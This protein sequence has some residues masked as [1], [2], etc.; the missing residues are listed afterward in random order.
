MDDIIHL[1]PDAVAN[2][3]AAGEVIQRP[4]SAV[5]EL[6]ENA[7]DAGATQIQ[8]VIK[9]AGRTLI[10]VCDNGKGMSFN[11]A[12]LCFERHATSKITKADDLFSIQTKGFRGE[13]LA[14]IAA[15]AHV[16]LK[17]K[18]PTDEIG[19]LLQIEGSEVKEHSP[20]ATQDG[21]T[22]SIKNL[23][24]NVPARRNFLKSDATEFG[25]IEDEFNR[26]AIIHHDIGFTLIHNGKTILQLQPAILR[27]R[28][29]NIFGNS[30]KDKLFPVEYQTDYISIFGFIS[31][32]ENVKKKK[33]E[34]FLFI[35]H[36]YVRHNLLNFAIESAY[37]QLIPEGHHPAYF[38][39]LEVNPATIDINISPTKVE[40]KLQNER[41]LFGVINATVKKAIGELAL[42]PQL[43]FDYNQEL[44]LN[45]V[46]QSGEL[47]IP[48]IH[49][50]PFFNPFHNSRDDK[51]FSPPFRAKQNINQ[52]WDSFLSEIKAAN[53]EKKDDSLQQPIQLDF[54][55]EA[56]KD[57]ASVESYIIVY[58]KYLIAKIQNQLLIINIVRA[59]ERIIYDAYLEAIKNKPIVVQHSLFPETITLSAAQAELLTEIKEEF[60]KLG[61][62]IE[63]MNNCQFAVNGTPNSEDENGDI[64]AMIENL[65]DDYQSNMMNHTVERDKNLALSLAKQK[66]AMMKPLNSLTEV[67]AF[68]Q[69][70]FATIL[71][72]LS[73]S[74]QKI[75]EIVSEENI[76]KIF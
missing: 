40:V 48:T 37:S 68:L 17:T 55:D 24:F 14:S 70:L 72:T 51:K 64:Q 22:I 32:P 43:D 41:L 31:K 8:L 2:Q 45:N 42:V 19:T 38:I 3:I 35:N 54:E 20:A 71:P 49:H 5:K 47:K 44:D 76:R 7:V 29:V 4:A 65:L 63:P 21:T 75:Y 23:F 74:G 36:R 39:C 52:N 28:I 58:E 10:Q 11:D 25:N 59:N 60:Q 27:Q 53:V 16:E 61:Y 33:N 73:P 57:M 13:A 15:I 56:D 12:R 66:R 46:P 6:L 9:D 18:R 30:F 69:Q 34:Q 67:T 1:L 62:E 50:D 26:V